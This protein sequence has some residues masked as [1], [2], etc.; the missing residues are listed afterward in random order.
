M[1]AAS[2][3]PPHSVDPA[4]DQMGPHVLKPDPAN[5][6]SLPGDGDAYGLHRVTAGHT[7]QESRSRSPHSPIIAGGARASHGADLP[8]LGAANLDIQIDARRLGPSAVPGQA[9]SRAVG[10]ARVAPGTHTR[11]SRHASAAPENAPADATPRPSG[12]EIAV[13]VVRHGHPWGHLLNRVLCTE[14]PGG[15]RRAELWSSTLL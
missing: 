11:P 14:A 3:L 10:T 8:Y 9:F 15:L 2:R 1:G 7:S 6:S 12:V 13:A 5:S 4:L